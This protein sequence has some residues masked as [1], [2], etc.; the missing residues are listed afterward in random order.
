MGVYHC[1]SRCVRW[2]FLCGWDDY[3]GRDFEHRREW[4]R[5][6]L[7]GLNGLFGV[8]VFAYAVMLTVPPRGN[9]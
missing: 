9:A 1:V 5:D 8:E 4:V 3:S 2:A 6:R 7:K